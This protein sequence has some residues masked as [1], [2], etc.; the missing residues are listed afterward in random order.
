MSDTG[1][2]PAE[3]ANAAMRR[4][5]NEVAGPRW[6]GRQ[7][8]Q[9]ARNVEMLA[10]LLAAVAARPG[11]RVLDIGCG[12]GVTTAPLAE[13]VGPS[14]HVAGVDISEPM[15]DAARQRIENQGLGNVELLLADAQVH[16]FTAV[17]FDVVTSR[18]G[19]MFFADPAAAFRN[20]RHALKPGGR[21]VMGVWATIAEN[22]HWKIPFEIAVRHLGQ[23]APQPPHAPGPHVFGD[24]AYLRG[25]LEA[26]GFAEIAVEPRQFHVHGDTALAMAEHASFFGAVQRLMDEKRADDATRQAIV[27]ETEAEF[28]AYATADGVRLPALFLLVSARPPN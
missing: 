10:Q 7:A 13:A 1:A 18:L 23:P 15:L 24:R 8:A 22:M 21:L 20:L 28:A 26:A 4:Y 27:R 3:T 9:E 16:E 25:T 17:S 2:S 12:T 6:V 19:V 14:G 11:E 5:W